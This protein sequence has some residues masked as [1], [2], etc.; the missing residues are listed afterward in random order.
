LTL[1]P[2]PIL[3]QLAP[4]GFFYGG[5][6]VVEFEPDSLWY[7][8]SLTIAAHAV[9]SGTKTEYHVFQHYS[10][11]AADAFSRLGVDVE[12][13]MR[14]GLLRIVDS[15]SQTVAHEEERKRA[16][17]S[18]PLLKSTQT[19]PLDMAESA[20]HWVEL[21]KAGF[22]EEEKR[23]LHIDDNT[24]IFLQYNDEKTT[25][26]TWRT[27]FAP[28]SIRAPERA[29]LYAFVKGVASD[30]FYAKFE[31][32]VD[33]IID[34]K[35]REDEGRMEHYIRIRNLKG[36]VFDSTWHRIQ[37]S[38]SGEVT[39]TSSPKAKELGIAGWLRGENRTRK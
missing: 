5:M 20:K 7:E 21:F 11:E 38:E 23:W 28:Y 37:V 18:D 35:A 13:S 36:K 14:D 8:L 12:R 26:D 10:R 24:T 29:A 31:A 2:V 9:K 34:L 17:A 22:P 16:A 3:D 39:M 32:L 30:G 33:G 1:C 6:Y 25:V 15:Y 19:T 4:K 27:A